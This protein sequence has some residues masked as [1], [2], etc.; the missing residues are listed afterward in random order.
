MKITFIS[1][2][3]FYAGAGKINNNKEIIKKVR[4]IRPLSHL[5]TFVFIRIWVIDKNIIYN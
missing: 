3:A 1:P 5:I 4:E 2:S